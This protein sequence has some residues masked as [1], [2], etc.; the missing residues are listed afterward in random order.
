MFEAIRLSD[1]GHIDKNSLSLE[2]KII[3]IVS[4]HE[5][6]LSPGTCRFKILVH[7]RMLITLPKAALPEKVHRFSEAT[8]ISDGVAFLIKACFFLP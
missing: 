6:N 4:E 2:K 8:L 1:G 5:E 3:K 7:Q